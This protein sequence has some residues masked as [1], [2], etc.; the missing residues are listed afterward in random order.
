LET[1][2]WG[3]FPLF[4]SPLSFPGGG[5]QPP[6]RFFCLGF[7]PL[8]LSRSAP[9]F[10]WRETQIWAARC[11]PPFSL[12][13]E[14]G[15]RPGGGPPFFFPPFPPLFQIAE[16]KGGPRPAAG[17]SGPA[18][19]SLSPRNPFFSPPKKKVFFSPAPPAPF[20][21][22]LPGHGWGGPINSNPIWARLGGFFFLFFF[23]PP[24]FLPLTSCP[25]PVS[26]TRPK[27]GWVPPSPPPSFPPLFLWGERNRE[28]TKTD[29]LE[30]G[31]ERA[32][33]NASVLVNTL[34]LSFGKKGGA[35]RG[36][37]LPFFFFPRGRCYF[38]TDPAGG[39]TKEEPGFSSSFT[40]RFRGQGRD[41]GRAQKKY[42]FF[43]GVTAN[44]SQ[45]VLSSPPPLPLRFSPG[46]FWGGSPKTGGFVFFFLSLSS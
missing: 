17:H 35:G 29:F 20:S 16:K 2:D 39:P 5:T 42:F 43:F 46:D 7:L 18:F 13:H 15:V 23:P 32:R 27:T 8:V 33:G 37:R 44:F 26:N 6:D 21:F 4:Y 9:P 25:P 3:P 40:G 28:K 38:L 22:F 11:N 30:G 14:K 24:F 1:P 19:L 34:P 36:G 31:G 10:F 41:L 12:L 45:G